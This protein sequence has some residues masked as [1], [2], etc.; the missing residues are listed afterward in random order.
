MQKEY[1]LCAILLP[2]KLWHHIPDILTNFAAFEMFRLCVISMCPSSYSLAMETHF[3][4]GV[5]R[6]QSVCHQDNT[7]GTEKEGF[8]NHPNT[9]FPVGLQ[10]LPATVLG[11]SRV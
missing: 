8:P 3:L 9:G 7:S 4:S 11:V 5:R 6:R 1:I 2:K 10:C